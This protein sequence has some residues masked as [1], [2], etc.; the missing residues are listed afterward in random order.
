MRFKG[1]GLTGGLPVL[2]ALLAL[3]PSGAAHGMTY[4]SQTSFGAFVS[5]EN[6]AEAL[7]GQTKN[8][9]Y[10][11]SARYFIKATDIGSRHLEFIT[12]VRNKYD[13]FENV[14]KELLT[15]TGA[16]TFQLR[17]LSVSQPE[18]VRGW[19]WTVGRFPLSEAGAINVDGGEAV[20]GWSRELKTSI[21]GGLNPRRA[22]QLYFDFNGDSQVVGTYTVY[23]PKADIGRSYFW[24]SNAAVGQL[25]QSNL[26]RFYLFN[27]STYRLSERTQLTSLIYLDFVPRLYFQT[28][29]LSWQQG[30]N[31]DFTSNINLMSI[32]VIEYTRRQGFLE[33]LPP[34]GYQ[35]GN[36][37]VQQRLNPEV[38]L[39]YNAALGLRQYDG[40]GRLELSAGPSTNKFLGPHYS[41][42]ALIG[43]GR[44]FSANNIFLRG[45]LG[46]YSKFW[47]LTLDQDIGYQIED[48]G[49]TLTPLTT[50]VSAAH[51]FSRQLYATLSLQRASNENVSILAGYFR[52]G[53]RFGSDAVPPLRDGAP[54]RG[55]L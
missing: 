7:D 17:Q 6:F 15:L 28:A 25:V 49:D 5:D 52:I 31:R 51:F 12:D 44:N 24:T 43:G 55:R 4:T 27:S 3:T 18:D 42:A 20:Y 39:L 50:E 32:D 54:P 11:L 48:S 22:D 19:G 34:S 29:Y 16:N 37:Q 1:L 47:E 38:Q 45:T 40:L 10:L 30:W 9:F 41:A 53:Y 26:D 8:D 13:F 14:D 46:Y 21:F 35:E 36:I 23:K 2:T 33:T